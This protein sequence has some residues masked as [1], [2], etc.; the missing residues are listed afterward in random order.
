MQ[1]D[2]P[3]AIRAAV[4]HDDGHLLGQHREDAQ[5]AVVGVLVRD[6]DR[7]EGRELRRRQLL[8]QGLRPALHGRRLVPDGLAREGPQQVL[9][10]IQ[11]RRMQVPQRAVDHALVEAFRPQPAARLLERHPAVQP[12][13]HDREQQ[14][15]G[16]PRQ[17]GGSPHVIQDRREHMGN[18]R[19]GERALQ[20]GIERGRGRRRGPGLAPPPMGRDGPGQE[21]PQQGV[22]EGG[23]QRVDHAPDRRLHAGAVLG[24]GAR[25]GIER[26][27]PEAR[28]LR[29]GRSRHAAGSEQRCR[30][31]QDFTPSKHCPFPPMR[32]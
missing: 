31:R 5:V 16:P 3:R 9:G 29:K 8:A 24:A 32:G 13:G 4:R 22:G 10:R 11:F 17:H 12:R 27:D 25:N 15:L 26:P 23:E 1:V 21:R 20:L 28:S 7:V 2:L 30:A 18:R 6:E 19:A 14:C